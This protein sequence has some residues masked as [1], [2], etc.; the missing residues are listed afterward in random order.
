MSFLFCRVQDKDICCP[1]GDAQVVCWSADSE[2]CR[3]SKHC[4]VFCNYL[5]SLIL[6]ETYNV[7]SPRPTTPPPHTHTHICT[8][9]SNHRHGSPCKRMQSLGGNICNASPI[10]GL[11]PTLLAA[12]AKLNLASK[13]QFIFF[14]M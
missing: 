12:G 6:T 11:N 1:P 10:S 13:S 2:C 5:T 3:M 14:G 9:A 7:T 8:L 4:Q